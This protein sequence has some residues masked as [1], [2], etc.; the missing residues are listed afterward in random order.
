MAEFA[1]MNSQHASIGTTP[2][3]LMYGYHPEIRWELEDNSLEG[4]VPTANERIK[5]LQIARDDATERLRSA[6][7]SQTKQY[8]KTYK[9][10]SYRVGELVM[11]STKNLKQK[12]P[13]K[14][15][16]H[17]FVGPFKIIDKVGAQAYRLLLPQIYRIHNTFHVSLLELYHLR[18]CGAASEDFMQAPELIDDDEMW[19]VEEVV[20]KVQNKQGVWYKVKWTGWGEEYNQWLPDKELKGARELTDAY[21]QTYTQAGNKRKQT[22][23]IIEP[24]TKSVSKRRRRHKS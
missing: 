4:R 16:S 1:Y 18:D 10:Q 6:R 22:Q 24:H 8:N 17:K 12:R 20:D 15:L 23:Q 19:E 13:S 3:F 21:K 14:K 2:F 9:P 7:D 5:M 11:L